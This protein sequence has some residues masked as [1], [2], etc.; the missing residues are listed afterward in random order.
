MFRHDGSPNFLTRQI[1]WGALLI[2]IGI[3]IG[4]WLFSDSYSSSFLSNVFTEALG[5]V[6]TVGII[7]VIY[8]HRNRIER[9]QRDEELKK[10]QSHRD[11][12]QHKRQL[13]HEVR[14]GANATAMGALRELS[15]MDLLTG[16]SS[17]LQREKLD[18]ANW[19]GADIPNINLRGADLRSTRLRYARLRKGDLGQASLRGADL[20]NADLVQA[21]LNGADLTDAN[22]QS[23]DFIE[24]QL[25]GTRLKRA[26]LSGAF[27]SY[28][29]LCGANL[30]DAKLIGAELKYAKFDSDTLLPD[31]TPWHHGV[32]WYRWT[33]LQADSLNTLSHF[34]DDEEQQTPMSGRL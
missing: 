32:D 3:G 28:A 33:E 15:R 10:E 18:N 22:L 1:A 9:A 20:R 26:D 24:A 34:T 14:S 21:N 5:L 30:T 27:L 6:A 25:R 11:D 4:Y 19:D 13:L 16:E 8:R 23:A 31:G 29:D 17:M 7:D 2:I 12:A